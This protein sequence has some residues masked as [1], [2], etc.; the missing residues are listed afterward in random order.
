[1]LRFSILASSE[2]EGVLLTDPYGTCAISLHGLRQLL[3]G[4]LVIPLSHLSL[5]CAQVLIERDTGV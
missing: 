3:I 5:L 2:A 1:L 4:K